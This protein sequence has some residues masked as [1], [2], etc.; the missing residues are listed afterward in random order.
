MNATTVPTLFEPE[1]LLRMQDGHRFELIDGRLKE[2]AMGGRSSLVGAE[3]TG[4][5]RDF[6]R[7]HRAGWVFNSE[8]GYQ[9][10]PHRPRLVR[11]ADAS[12]IRRGRLPDE[13]PY[14]GHTPIAPDL[15]VEVVSPNDVPP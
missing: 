1:D 9:C 14:E 6:A 4:L 5:L 10:F 13:A 7:A 2:R 12:F 15:A 3:I 8:A 11:F